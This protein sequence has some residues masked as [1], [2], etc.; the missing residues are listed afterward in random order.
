MYGE[1]AWMNTLT[2]QFFRGWQIIPTIKGFPR[3]RE[4]HKSQSY[5]Y[6]K[7]PR[8]KPPETFVIKRSGDIYINKLLNFPIR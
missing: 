3:I 2:N 1:I 7:L 4:I 5:I 8:A 6:L